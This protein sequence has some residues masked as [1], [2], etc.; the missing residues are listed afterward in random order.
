M[1]GVISWLR[2]VYRSAKQN[3]GL[4]DYQ[5]RKLRGIIARLV[6]V[7][8][9]HILVVF[10]KACLPR[11]KGAFTGQ[12]VR[13]FICTP[14]RVNNSRAGPTVPLERALPYPKAIRHYQ[15]AR[16]G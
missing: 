4:G 14:G 15:M 8:L 13:D 5:E 12:L 11:L 16:A 3:L 7:A 10:M 6:S 2:Q 1:R 9:V